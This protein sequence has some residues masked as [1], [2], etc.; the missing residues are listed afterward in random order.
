M[1]QL[2]KE[3][4]QKAQKFI[5]TT[6]R[7]LDEALFAVYI[8]GGSPEWALH[9]L[10]NFQ[11]EDGGFGH[12]LEPDLQ[13]PDSSVLAT[14]VALQILRRLNIGSDH[15]LVQ[16]A[17]RFLL[18]TYV[19]S[20]RAWPFIPP[21]SDSA[22]HAP[23]WQYDP[24]LS[25]YLANPRP[26]IVGFL[27]QYADFDPENLGESLLDDVLAHLESQ[28][29]NVEMHALLSYLRLLDT[30][31]LPGS[32]AKQLF[33]M[34]EPVVESTVARDGAGWERYGLKPL[35]VAPNPSA[36]FS[37][38]LTQAVQDNL[39]YEIEHQ[40]ED[41]SWAPPWSWG[42]SFPEAWPHA[43]R[44]WKGVLTVNTISSLQAYNRI[45]H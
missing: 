40:Q 30:K 15:N 42:G 17:I 37:E 12:G 44:A 9:E 4:F 3:G 10:S 27:I 39:D 19:P 2:S 26:E 18:N 1:I 11:N 14:T 41:G 6:A 33:E 22:P 25:Q 35:T 28:Q 38:F 34:L 16:G 31:G 43:E 45:N 5:N 13:L 20:A 24:D 29:G 21:S 7:P 23:W 36:P 32:I 8:I